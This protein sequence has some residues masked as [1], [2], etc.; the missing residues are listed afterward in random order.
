MRLLFT[1]AE[2]APFFKTGGLGDVAGALPKELARSGVETVVVLPY[3]TKISAAYQSQLEDLFHFEVAVG[4]RRQYC[5]VKRLKTDLV[6]YYFIDNRYYFDRE[7]LY[8]YYDDGE[9][10][11]FF[12]MA[13]IELLEKIDFIPD[14]LHVNDYHTAFIP[15]LLKEKYHWISAYRSIRTVLT[16]HNI[17]FQGQYSRSVLPDLF[18]MGTERYDDGTLRLGDALNFM[19]GGILYADR[20]TTVSPSYAQEIQTSEF[21]CGLD[22]ILRMESGKLQGILNGIDY[23]TND[24]K[25]DPALKY[26]YSVDNLTGK[27]KNKAALQ[28]ELGLEQDPDVPLLA[29]VSRLTYQKGFHLVLA[30]LN[31]LLQM[32]VQFVLLGTG[33]PD[34]ERSFSEIGQRFNEKCAICIDFDVKLAQRIYA[35]ADMFLMPSA[36]EP[37]GLSQMI[38]MRYGTLPIVHEIGGLKDTVTPFNPVEGQ[39]TGFGFQEFTSY[40][41]MECLKKAI[42]LYHDSPVT[43]QNM[44]HQAMIEDFSW[45]NSCSKYLDLYRSIDTI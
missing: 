8:G 12:Q 23:E 19:K 29:V 32:D 28:E 25:T 11:V 5:G 13:V 14:V 30:E 24:P 31:N 35:S 36:F 43:W 39:G 20:V 16:I 15:V 4:W 27:A 44:I 9:R 33:D 10:F 42:E 3:F 7:K 38:S 17:E 37:C 45:N 26:S 21:G 22:P 18:G 41:L 34:F 6:T 2:C 1:A 40:Q